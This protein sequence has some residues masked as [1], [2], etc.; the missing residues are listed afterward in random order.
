MQLLY[1]P[2]CRGN[3]TVEVELDLCSLM[4]LSVLH[5]LFT[6][7]ELQHVARILVI[8]REAVRV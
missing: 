4:W 1:F 3:V 7:I 6:E 5:T 8:Y 2:L